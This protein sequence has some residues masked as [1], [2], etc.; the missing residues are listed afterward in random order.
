MKHK[1]VGDS[2]SPDPGEYK[3]VSCGV[4]GENMD[5]K[6]DSYG[7]TSWAGAMGGSKRHHDLFT[8]PNIEEKW[9][10]QVKELRC[11][12]NKTPSAFLADRYREEANE[13]LADRKPTKEQWSTF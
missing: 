10:K 4:C 8:C 5:A 7:P 12:A 1:A 9:H 11:L 3:E 2:F 13:A 6:R